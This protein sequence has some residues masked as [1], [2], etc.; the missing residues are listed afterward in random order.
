MS[1]NIENWVEWQ[2]MLVKY[3]NGLSLKYSDFQV[4]SLEVCG[5][6]DEKVVEVLLIF[7]S[8]TFK[9]SKWSV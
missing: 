4:E 3:V 8:S 6:K 9:F 1:E 2:Q 7:V 5:N